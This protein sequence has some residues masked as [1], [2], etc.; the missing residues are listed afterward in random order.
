MHQ[1]EIKQFEF[2]FEFEFEL[3]ALAAERWSLH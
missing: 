2:E 1:S 3:V